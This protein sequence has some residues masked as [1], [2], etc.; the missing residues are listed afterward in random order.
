MRMLPISITFF[1]VVLYSQ[2][3]YRQTCLKNAT[4]CLPSS[5]G[6]VSFMNTLVAPPS[7]FTDIYKDTEVLLVALPIDSCDLNTS[8][9]TSSDDNVSNLLLRE[10]NNSFCNNYESKLENV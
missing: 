9:N 7:Q 5:L 2:F 6:I 1:C 10:T 3:G 4:S 8:G